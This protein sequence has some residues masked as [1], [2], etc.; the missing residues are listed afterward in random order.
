[1]KDCGTREAHSRP[2]NAM[3]AVAVRT[4]AARRINALSRADAENARAPIDRIVT[5]RALPE[6]ARTVANVAR[7]LCRVTQRRL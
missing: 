6:A 4:R 5:Q 7:L 2:R 1:M 3:R